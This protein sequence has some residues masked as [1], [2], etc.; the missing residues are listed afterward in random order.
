MASTVNTYDARVSKR[1]YNNLSGVILQYGWVDDY[2][3]AAHE[4]SHT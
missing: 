1:T 3:V 2:V 4:I